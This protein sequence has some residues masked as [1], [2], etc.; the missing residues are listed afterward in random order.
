MKQPTGLALDVPDIVR[1]KALALGAPGRQWLRDLPDVVH[2]LE[3]EWDVTVGNTLHGGSAAYVAAVTTGDGTPAVLKLQLPGYDELAEFASEIRVFQ[4]AAGRGYA[5]LL[6]A[7]ASRG[8]LLQER[9]GPRLSD[10]NLP[11][12]RQFEIIC[13]TLRHAWITDPDVATFP[14]GAEKA[15]WLRE[16]ISDAW[17][18][19]GQ[20]CS[21]GVIA[22]A[23]AH[24]HTREAAF[25][26]ARA[27]LVHGDAHGAN[28]LAPFGW[29]GSSDA[30]FA[31]VDP[32]GLFAEPAYDLGILMRGWNAELLA[33]NPLHLGH[34]RCAFL[35]RLTGE[36]P[37]AIWQWGVIERVSTG[38]FLIQIGYESEG[39]EYLHVAEAWALG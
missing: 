26:P 31:F 2:S 21:E 39:R 15:R 4:I 37:E 36:D 18:T 9:L 23:L 17:Q 38:L 13:A 1:G 25:D 35:S 33:G 10:L 22:Q 6:R 19:L 20:P 3:R 24:T 28:T 16:F 7:D 29:D 8:A 27:V 11:A 5:R 30:R 14:S 12:E 34:E 32:D